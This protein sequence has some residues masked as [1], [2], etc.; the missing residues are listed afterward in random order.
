[1]PRQARLD[2]PG[3]LHHVIARGIERKA[4]FVEERDYE[5]F[6]RRLERAVVRGGARVYA[7]ALLPNH[8]HL[9]L[10]TGDAGLPAV[11]RR[12]MTGYAVAFNLRHGRHGHLFQNRYRSIVVEEE[13]YFLQL[14]RYIHLNPLRAGLVD[15]LVRLGRQAYAGHGALLGVVERP[16]QDVGEVLGRF[17]RSVP[18]ARKRYEQFV[19]DGV[20]EG[21]RADL[22]GGGLRRSCG[23]WL[24]GTGRSR[25]E[26]PPAYDE[27]ILGSPEFVLD[28]LAE[29]DWERRQVLGKARVPL[30]S[31]VRGVTA[32]TG[33]EE[34]ELRSPSKRRAAVA[35][36][37]A[38]IEVAVGRLGYAG[39]AVARYLG[40]VP[41]TVNRW[42][43]HA[44]GS[45]LATRLLE[46][47]TR[48][49]C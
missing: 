37:R 46:E 26:G 10:R 22:V 47:V 23:A 8:F 30:D 20:G 21:H 40:V 35:A 31:L 17:G 14:V 6:L 19:A 25:E 2:A 18:T 45:E 29:A 27:R 9:L 32:L 41:S 38:L 34:N 44:R 42:P 43:P 39:A 48:G 36:R 15:S 28:T 11:M 3:T 5:D 49:M 1:M 12:I 13:P 16:W 7:W 4:I 33:V 24:E